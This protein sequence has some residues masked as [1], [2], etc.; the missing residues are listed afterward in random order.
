MQALGIKQR[1]LQTLLAQQNEVNQRLSAEIMMERKTW[2]SQLCQLQ[3]KVSVVQAELKVAQQD[4]FDAQVQIISL[5][6]NFVGFLVLAFH[7]HNCM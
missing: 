5:Y 7:W 3:E 2:Q 6:Q 1:S 4:S